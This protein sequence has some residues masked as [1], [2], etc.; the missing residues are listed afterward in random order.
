MDKAILRTASLD[1]LFSD[2]IKAYSV[3]NNIENLLPAKD[4]KKFIELK[5]KYK[6]AV[7]NIDKK[8]AKTNIKRGFLFFA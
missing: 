2:Y 5:N 8:K 1:L 3:F 7:K 4:K 6:I